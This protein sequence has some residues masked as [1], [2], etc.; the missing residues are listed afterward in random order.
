MRPAWVTLAILVSLLFL[1]GV[2]CNEAGAK[3][4]YHNETEMDLEVRLD[5]RGGY[6]ELPAETTKRIG[7]GLLDDEP[8]RL[9]VHNE[10]G[11]LAYSLDTTLRELRADQGL[12]ITIREEDVAKCLTSDAGD[13]AGAD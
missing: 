9:R 2:A 8:F 12:T 13:E 7:F 5:G 11:C 4:T 1:L 3:V 6:N 10:S